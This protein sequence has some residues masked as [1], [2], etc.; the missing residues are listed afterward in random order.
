MVT[1]ITGSIAL[2]LRMRVGIHLAMYFR[3]PQ[4]GCYCTCARARVVPKSRE[5]LNRFPLDLVQRWG[6]VSRVACN[7]KSQL[8]PT[9][10]VPTCKVTFPDLK[11]GWTDSNLVRG[12]G[13]VSRVQCKSVD[14]TPT[15]FRTCRAQPLAPSFVAP[16]RRFT[17]HNIGTKV[18]SK[19]A[20]IRECLK[21]YTA[22]GLREVIHSY[23]NHIPS[24]ASFHSR[25]H[26]CCHQNITLYH[27]MHHHFRPNLKRMT[28]NL[29][30]NDRKYDLNH[31]KVF[32]LAKKL[33]DSEYKKSFRL[34]PLSSL[35]HNLLYISPKTFC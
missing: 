10:H 23:S 2:K 30:H 31:V 11:N 28:S 17:G 19:H 34:T 9:L 35:K 1:V 33:V 13:P 7:S 32:I 6:P 3:L 27:C 14:S 12:Q 15:Q 24:Y 5:R 8:G 29:K 16:K 25:M 20:S 18:C 22:L 4:L 21:C 26:L